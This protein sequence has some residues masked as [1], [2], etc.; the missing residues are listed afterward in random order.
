MLLSSLCLLLLAGC[1]AS[2]PAPKSDDYLFGESIT[3]SAGKIAMIGKKVTVSFGDVVEDSR[4]PTQVTCVWQGVAKVK[5][6]VIIIQ[7][8][9][10][11]AQRDVILATT[12]ESA[13][14]ASINGYRIEL[15][16]VTPWPETA[17]RIEPGQYA[18]NLRVTRDE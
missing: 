12:P 7:D 13:R 2:R 18:V 6:G 1:A 17:A 5:F 9:A 16:D 15:I 8:G 10:G 4:C 14:V 11:I 3:M